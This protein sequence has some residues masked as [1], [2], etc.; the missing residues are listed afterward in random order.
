MLLR[1]TLQIKDLI[2]IHVSNLLWTS[3]QTNHQ[4]RESLRHL[5][6][7]FKS[8]AKIL[9]DIFLFISKEAQGKATFSSRCVTC[10][11]FESWTVNQMY[12]ATRFLLHKSNRHCDFGRRF[13]ALNDCTSIRPIEDIISLNPVFFYFLDLLLH[14]YHASV[15]AVA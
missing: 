7:L 15:T 11:Y 8:C 10:T 3:Y 14:S 13:L 1:L 9:F 4:T 12:G 6:I 2:W 5:V